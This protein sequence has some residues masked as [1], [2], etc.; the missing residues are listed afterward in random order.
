MTQSL[1]IGVSAPDGQV[2]VL[3]CVYVPVL[4]ESHCNVCFND[5]GV[6][7]ATHSLSVVTQSLVIGADAP[8]GQTEVL[9]CVYVPV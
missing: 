3:V 4:G 7:G 1:V 9:V 5:I 6:Q 2:E 8:D